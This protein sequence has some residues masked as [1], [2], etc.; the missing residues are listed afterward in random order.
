MN[1]IPERKWQ[2]SEGTGSG[3]LTAKTW[4]G[5][6]GQQQKINFLFMAKI[7]IKRTQ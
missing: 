5:D 3:M 1:G 4:R 7:L 6:N 2:A